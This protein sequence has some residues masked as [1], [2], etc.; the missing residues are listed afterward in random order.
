MSGLFARD[1]YHI[2]T[3]QGIEASLVSGPVPMPAVQSALNQHMFDCALLVSAGNRPYWYNGLVLLGTFD[4][5][6]PLQPS[7]DASPPLSLPLFPDTAGNNQALKLRLLR[8]CVRH[9][10][11]CYVSKSMSILF[12]VQR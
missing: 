1:I 8:I 9:T 11:I 4:D 2:L 12:V 3:H 5:D 10:S 7:E 6:L